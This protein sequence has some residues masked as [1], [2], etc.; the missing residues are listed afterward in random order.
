MDVIDLIGENTCERIIGVCGKHEIMTHYRPSAIEFA[1]GPTPTPGLR[2][3]RFPF[4]FATDSCDM[5]GRSL[6]TLGRSVSVLIRNK[7]LNVV[8]NNKFNLDSLGFEVQTEL[9]PESGKD[10]IREAV[11]CL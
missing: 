4:I 3:A 7:R 11:G 6:S 1:T 9:L 8:K 2:V 5:Q 10:R